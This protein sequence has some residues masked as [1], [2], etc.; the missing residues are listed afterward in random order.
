MSAGTRGRTFVCFLKVTC[1][2]W[3]SRGWSQG[4][5]TASSVGFSCFL[6]RLSDPDYFWL[7]WMIQDNLPILTSADQEP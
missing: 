1:L 4:V 3:V 2:E 6:I 5:S 7:A